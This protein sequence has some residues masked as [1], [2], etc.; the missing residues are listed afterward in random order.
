MLALYR[1]LSLRYLGQRRSRALLVVASIALGVATLV[2]TRLL[3]KSMKQ[4]T[5]GAATPLSGF[6]DLMIGNGDQGLPRDLVDELKRASIGGIK[7]MQPL[8]IGRVVLPDIG[9]RSVLLLGV[10]LQANTGQAAA[11]GIDAK[12]TNPLALLSGHK[13]A[14]I[15]IGLARLLPPGNQLLRLR[16]AGKESRLAVAG[17]IDATGPAATL[18]GSVI[19][20][21]LADAAE[22]VG[23]PG[24]V[25]RIDIAL[26]AGRDRDLV[27][28]QLERVLAGR[29]EVRLPETNDRMIRDVVGGLEM[30]FSLGG[31]GAL[32][33]GL[34]LVYNALSVSVA[35]RRHDIGILRSLGGTRLQVAGLFAGEACFMGFC[36]A[37]LGIPLGVAMAHISAGPLHQILSDVLLPAD[38]A[39]ASLTREDSLVAALAG[40]GTALLAALLPAMQAAREEP[41]DAVRRVPLLASW[42]MRVAQAS[43][44]MLLIGVGIAFLMLHE[45][46]PERWG[47]YVSGAL[48]LVGGLL[49]TPLLAA[50]LVR[51]L[52]PIIRVSLGIEGRLAADSLTRSPGRTGLVIA[53]LAAG[54]ALL[55][56]T[57]GI[58]HSSEQMIV[59]WVDESFVSELIVTANSQIAASGDSLEME[60]VLGQRIASLPG[61]ESVVPIRFRRPLVG[62]KMVFVIALDAADY[63]NAVRTRGHV[64][65]MELFP[66]LHQPGTILVSENYAAR[67]GVAVGDSITLPGRRGPVPLQ[68]IGTV[69]D[70]SW[71]MGT[72]FIDRQQWKEM[73]DDPLVD[74]FDVFVR[75]GTNVEELRKAIRANWEAEQGVLVM[76]QGE[77][78]QTIVD[79]IRRLY[80]IT[81]AQQI[82][83]MMVAGLGVVT[84]LLISVLQRQRELGLL[85]A[86][87]A[88]RFQVVRSLLAEAALMGFLG[89]VIGI[90]LGIPL[91]WYAVRIILFEET[92]F[93]FPVSIPWT[94][95]ALLVAFAMGV[96]VLAGLVPAL[97][98]MRLRIPE[99]IAY[100]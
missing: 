97:H 31:L 81:Y 55:L 68:I 41:A 20:M 59:P 57:A 14:F 75:P 86:V 34:F 84:A 51:L 54:T 32:I 72:L 65:G 46:L 40:I 8:I 50:S 91:E 62:D 66:K 85:R 61:V 24:T 89:A 44:S 30:G 12:L 94:A 19:I 71:N 96:A 63:Y 93:V 36:G 11:W 27:R 99:A 21:R 79:M 56:E 73:A 67:H 87:G 26:A 7:D 5:R 13:P 78:R 1:T 22:L 4:A 98:A 42:S 37:A 18:G 43:S 100:E 35:E 60:E 92:G 64:P 69:V 58:T 6:A 16:A 29:A 3:N 25:S 48:V 39:G 52:Q 76:T 70:Y 82:V 47:T 38:G 49:I 28:Q 74:C 53:A 77:V 80:G 45:H 15:G 88:S 9:N 23:R 90:V 83:V 33:V 17:T 10:N 95:A 2:A